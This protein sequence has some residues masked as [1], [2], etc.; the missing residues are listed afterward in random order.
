MRK[1]FDEGV[2]TGGG[3]PHL[4]FKADMVKQFN[5]G[6]KKAMLKDN[7]NNE[8]DDSLNVSFSRNSAAA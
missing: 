2:Y 4:Q 7:K 3:L 6:N 1:V 8:N 5:A